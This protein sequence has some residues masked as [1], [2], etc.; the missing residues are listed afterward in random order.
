M[1]NFHGDRND[2]LFY[3]NKFL[4]DP[5]QKVL[6]LVSVTQGSLTR[7]IFDHHSIFLRGEFPSNLEI[8]FLIAER[9]ELFAEFLQAEHK[10]THLLDW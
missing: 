1:P 2:I 4:V 5:N 8:F 3:R 10:Q 6:F 7:K 9:Q